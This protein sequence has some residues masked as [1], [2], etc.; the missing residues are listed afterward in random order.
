M[1][2]SELKTTSRTRSQDS[3]RAS[4]SSQARG[5]ISR[6]VLISFSVISGLTG[7][8]AAACIVGGLMASGGPLAMVKAWFSAVAGL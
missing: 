2:H 6:G 1:L 4:E 7:A 3:V 8:W 5:E